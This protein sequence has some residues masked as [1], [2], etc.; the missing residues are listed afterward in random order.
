MIEV[1]RTTLC[2]HAPS[3]AVGDNSCIRTLTEGGTVIA[4][5]N[6]DECATARQPLDVENLCLIILCGT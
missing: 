6:F 2:T 1:G 5:T 4:V 3:V